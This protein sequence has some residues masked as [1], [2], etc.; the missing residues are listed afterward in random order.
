MLIWISFNKFSDRKIHKFDSWNRILVLKENSMLS[1]DKKHVSR[2]YWYLIQ[3]L[4]FG[5]VTTA[6]VCVVHY[7]DLY[8]HNK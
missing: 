1:E 3:H 6:E 8:P 7:H 4:A 5:G 2:Q